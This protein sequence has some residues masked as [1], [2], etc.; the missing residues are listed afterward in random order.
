MSHF[1]CVACKQAPERQA[2]GHNLLPKG[3]APYWQSGRGIHGAQLWWG[4]WH[5]DRVSGSYDDFIMRGQVCHRWL[6]RLARRIPAS[7]ISSFQDFITGVATANPIVHLMAQGT[8]QSSYQV[9]S[10]S[11]S[12]HAVSPAI[13]FPR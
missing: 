9:P 2:S 13:G 11:I 5:G 3:G 1:I 7:E 6:V 8:V 10:F 12:R 4:I